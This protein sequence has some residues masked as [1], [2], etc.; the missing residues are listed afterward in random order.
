MVE[1]QETCRVKPQPLH[2]FIGFMYDDEGNRRHAD[3]DAD[4]IIPFN[5]NQVYTVIQAVQDNPNYQHYGVICW[6]CTAIVGSTG[7]GNT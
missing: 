6:S 2:T 1:L 5:Q 4:L 3:P 7:I